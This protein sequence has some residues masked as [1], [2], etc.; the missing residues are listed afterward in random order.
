M[1]RWVFWVLFVAGMGL[2]AWLPAQ[3]ALPELGRQA[4]HVLMVAQKL[5]A[6]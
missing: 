3:S 2:A 1:E 5:V 4:A 6:A